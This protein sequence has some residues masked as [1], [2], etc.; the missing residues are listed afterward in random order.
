MNKKNKATQLLERISLLDRR[1][2]EVVLR[3]LDQLSKAR[4]SASTR[5]K[6]SSP[7]S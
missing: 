6:A 3:Y 1:N 5:S 4:M 2:Q 7:K